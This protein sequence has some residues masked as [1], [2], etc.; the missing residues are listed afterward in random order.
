MKRKNS[1][2][3]TDLCSKHSPEWIDQDQLLYTHIAWCVPLTASHLMS[4]WLWFPF[5]HIFSSL[6]MRQFS[7]RPLFIS[8]L[9]K[10]LLK[11]RVFPYV[12]A[13]KSNKQLWQSGKIILLA[14]FPFKLS[15]LFAA[16]IFF[17]SLFCFVLFV[18][19]WLFSSLSLKFSFCHRHKYKTTNHLLFTK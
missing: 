16:F 3:D 15:L 2:R 5:Y 11:K 8:D 12:R 17:F 19:S 1:N 13:T 6:S 18:V 4:K 14:F 10:H 7:L 9:L